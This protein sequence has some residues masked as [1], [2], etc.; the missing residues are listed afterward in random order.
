M[1]DSSP[2]PEAPCSNPAQVAFPKS[3][4]RTYK[5][6]P[7]TDL[8]STAFTQAGPLSFAQSSSVALLQHGLFPR[9]GSNIAGHVGYS[10]RRGNTVKRATLKHGKT[11]GLSSML[12]LLQ[13]KRPLPS[14]KA[15]PVFN[16]TAPDRVFSSPKTKLAF[17]PCRLSTEPCK[18][19]P[20]P[21]PGRSA[22]K[23]PA[24]HC[25]CRTLKE[26]QLVFKDF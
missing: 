7:P 18:P 10:N 5:N 19:R 2:R 15:F 8:T 9:P 26:K 1:A 20:R 23:A 4:K 13:S 24:G 6:C 22:Q 14:I 16:P 17:C 11:C 21:P 25:R 3:S 12:P